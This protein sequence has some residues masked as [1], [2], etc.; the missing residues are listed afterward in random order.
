MIKRYKR[1]RAVGS[2]SFYG[3]PVT[4]LRLTTPSNLSEEIDTFHIV[5]LV[6]KNRED[7]CS[8]VHLM[9]R[10]SDFYFVAFTPDDI[11]NQATWFTFEDCPIPSYLKQIRLTQ[12]DCSYKDM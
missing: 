8:S 5:K 3:K 12:Y 1:L 2:T 6:G 11:N 7:N 9:F 10:E 4:P